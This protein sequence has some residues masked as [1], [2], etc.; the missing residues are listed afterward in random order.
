MERPSWPQAKS[1][2]LV[3]LAGSAAVE[4]RKSD[5][6]SCPAA[7]KEKRYFNAELLFSLT[8]ITEAEPSPNN[9]LGAQPTR[10]SAR[11]PLPLQPEVT[12]DAEREEVDPAGSAASRL[13]RDRGQGRRHVN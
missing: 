9:V 11:L 10:S 4:Q 3:M 2:F 7:R 6:G 12:R 1:D 5:R 13:V 8:D